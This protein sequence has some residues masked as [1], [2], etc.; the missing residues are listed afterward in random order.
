MKVTRSY[1]EIDATPP[2]I[3]GKIEYRI[4]TNIA[5][6]YDGKTLINIMISH[7]KNFD[8][9]KE[10]I[11]WQSCKTH[12]FVIDGTNEWHSFG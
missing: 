1:Q 12:T 10:N 3:D 8:E 9:N 11:C 6:A 4:E 2:E 7:R 5:V